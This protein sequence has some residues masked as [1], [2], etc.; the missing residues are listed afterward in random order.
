MH[1]KKNYF[2]FRGPVKIIRILG[3]GH[4]NA[5][6]IFKPILVYLDAAAYQQTSISQTCSWFFIPGFWFCYQLALVCFLP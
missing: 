1:A 5:C 2:T 3:L 4:S 6:W